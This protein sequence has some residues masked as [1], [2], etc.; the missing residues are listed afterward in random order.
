MNKRIRILCFLDFFYPGYKA[1]GPIKTI[2]SMVQALNK[3][4]DFYIVTRNHDLNSKNNYKLVKHNEWVKIKGV[5]V[6]YMS[7]SQILR[8]GLCSIIDKK[9][10]KI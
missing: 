9:Y 2:L 8:F 7:K 4:F 6:Y 1:G 10:H 3:E 5:N